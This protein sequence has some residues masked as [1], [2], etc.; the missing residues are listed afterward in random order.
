[1][2]VPIEVAVTTEVNSVSQEE[3]LLNILKIVVDNRKVDCK[4]SHMANRLITEAVK[5][6]EVAEVE[7]AAIKVSTTIDLKPHLHL[8]L[9]SLLQASSRSASRRTSDSKFKTL[10][11]QAM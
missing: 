1:V 8:T 6:R 5:V 4:K 2:V 7:E 10:E 3:E 11:S 9:K